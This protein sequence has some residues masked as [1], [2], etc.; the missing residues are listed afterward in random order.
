M[1]GALDGSQFANVHA[2]AAAAAAAAGLPAPPMAPMISHMPC[3]PSTDCAKGV[4]S[5]RRPWTK[6]EDNAIVMLVADNG[7][8]RWSLI[9]ECLRDRYKVEGRTGKQ[10]RERWHNHLDPNINKRPWSTEEEMI[11]FEAHAQLGNKWAE[12]AKRLPGR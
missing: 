10:C 3:L 9:A 5:V 1:Y 7:T 2:V 8:K 6:E 4:D 11:I 12:I